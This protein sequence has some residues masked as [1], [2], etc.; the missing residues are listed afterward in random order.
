MPRPRAPQSELSHMLAVHERERAADARPAWALTPDRAAA[1]ALALGWPNHAV[2]RTT[3]A[4]C[5]TGGE[6]RRLAHFLHYAESRNWIMPGR[7]L[8]RIHHAD[9]LLRYAT[10]GQ[11]FQLPISA[12]INLRQ[13]AVA[14]DLAVPMMTDERLRALIMRE[15]RFLDNLLDR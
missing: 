7:V 9:A 4:A 1:Y 15:Y 13:A 3:L 11:P 2:T 12:F 14:L 6:P 10:E 8:I 5:M